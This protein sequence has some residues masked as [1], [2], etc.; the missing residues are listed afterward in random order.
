MHEASMALHN[1]SMC[2]VKRWL[3]FSLFF[4][5]VLI[6]SVLGVRVNYECNLNVSTSCYYNLVD[7]PASCGFFRALY[8]AELSFVRTHL[9]SQY[10]GEHDQQDA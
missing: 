7:D 4:P 8:R 5:D 9:I 10:F 1:K 2:L 6:R 3:N